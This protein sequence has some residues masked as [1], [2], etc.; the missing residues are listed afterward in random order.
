M[1]LIAAHAAWQM[2]QWQEMTVFVDAVDTP[3]MPQVQS[4]ATG[5]FLRSVLCVRHNQFDAAR[6]HIDR[7]RELMGTELAALVGK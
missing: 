4:T 2:G 5:A 6:D 1:A 7:A 3:D